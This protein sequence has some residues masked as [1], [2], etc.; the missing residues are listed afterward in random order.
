MSLATDI[1]Q[2]E[3]LPV[4]E[5]WMVSAACGQVPANLIDEIYYPGKGGST[6]TAKRICAE[7]PVQE[8]CLA[9][10]LD[11]RERWGVW[12]GKSERERRRLEQPAADLRAER[13]AAILA[14]YAEGVTQAALGRRHGLAPSTVADIIQAAQ[15][16]TS[17]QP[18]GQQEQA[19]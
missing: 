7:C 2:E 8:L 11:N 16:V 3:E 13:N 5:A 4:P 18:T 9:R 10:A 14:G 17:T 1:T 6:R 19:A 15:A 12:G